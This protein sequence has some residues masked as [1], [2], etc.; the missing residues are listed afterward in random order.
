MHKD[1]STLQVHVNHLLLLEQK[2]VISSFNAP[3]SLNVEL[4]YC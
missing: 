2:G 3:L 4:V 1:S